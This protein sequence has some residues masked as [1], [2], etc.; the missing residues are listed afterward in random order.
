[1]KTATKKHYLQVYTGNGK[2]KTTSAAGLA[3]RGVAHGWQVFFGQF[4]K[5]S[6]SGEIT[7]FAER[8]PE[9][10]VEQ[11]GLGFFLR[12]SPTPED[13]QA[14]QRGLARLLSIAEA[15]HHSMIIADEMLIA[16]KYDLVSQH[17]VLRLADACESRAELILT[18]RYAPDWLI[19]RADLVSEIQ[20]LKH[21]YQKGVPARKGIER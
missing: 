17:E 4:I 3:L 7:L 2:G 11:F 10:T 6:P 8:F 18:G 20:P 1:M 13:E 21:Y 15:G 12:R 14:A 5:N 16:L 9:I 19:E